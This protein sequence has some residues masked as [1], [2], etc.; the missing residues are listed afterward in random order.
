MKKAIM[1]TILAGYTA[2]SLQGAVFKKIAL[3][4]K[5]FFVV[6]SEEELQKMSLA[7]INEVVSTTD[8]DMYLSGGIAA[9]SLISFLNNRSTVYLGAA[10]I[11]PQQKKLLNRNAGLALGLM[12]LSMWHFSR[13]YKNITPLIQIRNAKKRAANS[14]DFKN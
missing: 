4:T 11:T 12:A 2:I 1:L 9:V 7:E 10:T 14:S 13:K 8:T 3:K 6:R 5:S